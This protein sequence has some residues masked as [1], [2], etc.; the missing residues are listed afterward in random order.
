MKRLLAL[1]ALVLSTTARAAPTD[2]NLRAYTDRAALYIGMGQSPEQVALS[3]RNYFGKPYFTTL[4]NGWN[5][6]VDVV[7]QEGSGNDITF[8]ATLA[9]IQT[10]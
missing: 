7:Y 5:L 6:Q 10:K 3:L 4:S 2:A 9:T 1:F 8:L